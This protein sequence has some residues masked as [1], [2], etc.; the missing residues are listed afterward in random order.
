MATSIFEDKAVKPTDD[1]INTAIAEAKPLWGKLQAHFVY[2]RT[3]Q[4]G[5]LKEPYIALF[6]QVCIAV[7]FVPFGKSDCHE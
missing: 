6:M 1:M 7:R 4:R 2:I 3:I 5:Q